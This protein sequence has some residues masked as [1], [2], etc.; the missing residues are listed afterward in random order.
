MKQD[1]KNIIT[2]EPAVKLLTQTFGDLVSDAKFMAWLSSKLGYYPN[3]SLTLIN[4]Y[5]KVFVPR[6][7]LPANFFN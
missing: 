6:N 2:R 4:D 7:L 5:K 3:R 1:L